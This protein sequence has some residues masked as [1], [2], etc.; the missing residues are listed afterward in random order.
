MP[1]GYVCVRSTRNHSHHYAIGLISAGIFMHMEIFS[2]AF[3][4]C[5]FYF[6]QI[7]IGRN[8]K[9]KKKTNHIFK[10]FS[11]KRAEWCE[12]GF[13]SEK[14][15]FAKYS[16]ILNILIQN[17][18]YFATLFAYSYFTNL[19]DAFTHFSAPIQLH[20]TMAHY[21]QIEQRIWCIAFH[22][23]MHL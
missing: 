22:F 7:K 2:L 14:N 5:H 19:L 12:L 9:K 6:C 1:S 17:F 4:S 8:I 15:L 21:H 13:L 23:C 16:V 11:P 10:P 3:P 18:N 20:E